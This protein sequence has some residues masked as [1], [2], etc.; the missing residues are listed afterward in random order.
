[1]IL[2][3]ILIHVIHRLL[4][5]EKKSLA[6][7]ALKRRK[8]QGELIHQAEEQLLQIN[9]LISNVEMA[10]VQAEVVKAIETGTVALR[11]MQDEVNLQYVEKLMDANAELQGE[12][13]D[14]SEMLAGVQKDDKDVYDEYARLE[15]LI[16]SEKVAAIPLVPETQPD[17]VATVSEAPVKPKAPMA[18]MI[19]TVPEFEEQ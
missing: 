2:C 13:H 8:Q 12:V 3:P 14:I 11:K 15:E 9:G 17:P 6:L 7:L 19:R 4:S 5:E 16:A 1:M 18:Q 10:V